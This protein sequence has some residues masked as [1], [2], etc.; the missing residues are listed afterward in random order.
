MR[1]SDKSWQ[2]FLDMQ[3][4]PENYSDEQLETMMDDLDQVPDVD[5]AWKKI[6]QTHVSLKVRP[7]HRWQQI[8]A[9]IIGVVVISCIAIAAVHLWN[10]ASNSSK[11]GESPLMT[12][13]VGKEIY[14]S[15]DREHIEPLADTLIFDNVP[16]DTMLMDIASFYHVDAVFRNTD[17]RQLRFYFVW[18][19]KEGLDELIKKLNHFES[20]NVRQEG[21]MLIVE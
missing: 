5:S 21:T 15:K 16:L 4:H 10:S 18:K 14:T 11:N 2:M 6:E 7:L 19:P 12:S 9:A 8:A 3:E 13:P 20:L 17:A 1:P